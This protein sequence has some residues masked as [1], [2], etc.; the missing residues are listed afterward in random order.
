MEDEYPGMWQRWFKEQC[1]AVGWAH[2]WG[3]R[4][5][6][7]TKGG[8]GWNI[9]RKAIQE[10][11]VGD[12]V[13]VAL[14]NNR[15]GRIG[16]ITGKAIGDDEWDPLAPPNPA[17]KDMKNGEMGRR[18]FVR[19]ELT[20]GPDNQDLVVQLPEQDRFN[21][22]Q[23]RLTV[24]RISSMKVG[25]L[26]KIMNDPK[27]WVNL[28]GKFGYEKALSDYISNYPNR[29]EDGLLPHPNKK[30]REN[31]FTDK[32]RSDVLLIDRSNKSVVVECKQHSP[33]VDDIQQLRHYMTL[34]QQETGEA[35]RG[36]LV[37]GGA[38]KISSAVLT[39]AK[40]SPRV[41]IVSYSIEV[42]F[43]ESF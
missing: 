11:A 35:P 39:A 13:I 15:V 28:L 1:V 10:M 18:I 26:R 40:R 43:R 6:G 34:L 25:Q 21:G 36:I 2:S 16:Q 42:N 14:K 38:P 20:T 9:A 29:L 32:K 19:W 24:A 17:I 4:L 22:A 30:I 37:H 41:E 23:L 12:Y 27:N 7:K 33:S 31:V 5:G 3:F 8:L